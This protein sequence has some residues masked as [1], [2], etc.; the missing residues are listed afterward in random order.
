MSEAMNKAAEKKAPMDEEEEDPFALIEKG[1]ALE[2]A[3]NHWGSADMYSR[4][5]T[6]LKIRADN[7]SSQL[8]PDDNVK[9]EERGKIISLYRAQSLK[10]LYKA[11]HCFIDAVKFENDQDRNR[12]MEVAKSGQGKL[13]PLCSMLSNEE[14]E[15]RRYVFQ[16]LFSGQDDVKVKELHGDEEDNSINK[17]DEAGIPAQN[18]I[19]EYSI[20]PAEDIDNLQESMEARLA[21]L[22]SSLANNEHIPKAPPPF[23]SG[24]RS[25]VGGVNSDQS[26]LDSLQR[27]LKGLGITLPDSSRNRDFIPDNLSD[28]DQVK[29]IM[30]QARDEVMIDKSYICDEEDEI[31]ENDSMFEGFEEDEDDIDSLLARAE[32]LVAKTS[33][34][35]SG[36]VDHPTASCPSSTVE[37]AQLR[38]AQALLL[39]ARLC[40]EIGDAKY[41]HE[42]AHHEKNDDSAGCGGIGNLDD[43]NKGN[44]DDEKK[45]KGKSTR[46]KAKESVKEANECLEDILSGWRE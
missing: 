31:D 41:L 8:L 23:I 35:I 24:S 20:K 32:N 3:T 9:N 17:T 18:D 1:N 22:N 30:Q 45:D 36:I 39:E 42:F 6:S 34:E 25:G 11:R 40:L 33:S 2:A 28:E 43:N 15:R 44:G 46:N 4:A 19:N 38:K 26:R 16:A 13:D 21:N 12:M 7:I 37:L 29:L 14:S 27:G 5:S 10:Y